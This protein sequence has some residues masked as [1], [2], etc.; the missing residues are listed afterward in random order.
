MKATIS[1]NYPFL[2]FLFRYTEEF[3][4]LSTADVEGRKLINIQDEESNPDNSTPLN[5]LSLKLPDILPSILHADLIEKKAL[6]ILNAPGAL[7]EYP[8]F[9][10][11]DN[12]KKFMV[13]RTSGQF[14]TV[15][16]LGESRTS[17]DC[18]GF[19][20]FL[21]PD[22]LSLFHGYHFLTVARLSHHC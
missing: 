16:I 5:N 14:Y 13:A 15:K 17:C 3:H 18:K 1:K 6:A 20:Y 21:L 10:S 12:I 9:H 7:V 2:S 4:K 11:A 19:R 8:S 22:D